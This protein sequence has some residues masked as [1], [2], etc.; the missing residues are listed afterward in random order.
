LPPDAQREFTWLENTFVPGATSDFLSEA[1]AVDRT[2]PRHR[3]RL[4]TS[5]AATRLSGSERE[6]PRVARSPPRHA[7]RLSAV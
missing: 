6:P 7:P 4:K 3:P 5:I 2:D 1:A